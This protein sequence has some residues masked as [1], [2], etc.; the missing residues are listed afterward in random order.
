MMFFGEQIELR[1]A[2]KKILKKYGVNYI[3]KT[4]FNSTLVNSTLP[5]VVFQAVKQKN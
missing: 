2:P 5:L 1:V 3:H 4:K